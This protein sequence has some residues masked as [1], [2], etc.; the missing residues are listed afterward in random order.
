LANCFPLF[1]FTF[2]NADY[3]I[4]QR[5]IPKKGLGQHFLNDRNIAR[6]IVSA[7]QAEGC[8]SI[9]EI[10][11]GT[12]VLT[13]LL[14]QIKDT[15]TY[16]VEIDRDAVSLLRESFPDIRERL[17]H[18]DFLSLDMED[19]FQSPIAVIGNLPYY[20]SSQVFFKILENRNRVKEVVC[21]V[22]K[23][24]ARRIASPPGSRD[25]GILSV[26]L[27]AFY[28]V[29][30]LFSVKPGAFNPPPRVNSGV[31]RMV[32]RAELNL[33]CDEDKFFR[34]VKTSFNQRRKMLK[35]SLQNRFVFLNPDNP[36]LKKRPEQ[37]S[38]SDFI[39]LTNQVEEDKS[40]AD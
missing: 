33:P 16:F 35:N 26:L 6:K 2:E 22:Q 25:Y 23:E 38:V 15:A 5:I 24:V 19:L 36:L 7:L 39:V 10:G 40:D 29:D 30:Y 21:M 12:G 14:A 31:I 3:S 1:S 8:N 11:P 18:G 9:V 32:R 27:Q 28:S 4:L 17:V 37:L 20:I 13:A 34:V